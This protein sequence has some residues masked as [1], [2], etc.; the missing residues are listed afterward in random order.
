MTIARRWLYASPMKTIA[1]LTTLAVFA[2]W[3]V[4]VGAQTILGSRFD[5]SSKGTPESTRLRVN[6]A[7]SASPEVVSGDAAT[8][9]ATVQIIVNGGTPSTLTITLP[10][11]S[12]WKR[13]PF[14]TAEPVQAWKYRDSI[15]DGIVSPVANLVIARSS[16]GKFKLAASLNGRDVPLNVTPGNPGTYAGMVVTIPGGGTYCANFGGVAGGTILR[17]DAYRFRIAKPTAEGTCPTTGPPVCGDGI[18]DSPFETCDVANDAACP[19]ICGANG[20][21]CLCPF[22]GDGTIDPGE[23]CDTLATGS[24][25]E[26]CSY[27]CTCSVCGDGVIQAPGEECE[28]FPELE[29]TIGSCGLPGEPNQCRCPTCGDG[30]VTQGEECD[31]GSDAACPGT[32]NTDLCMCAVCGNMIEEPGEECD[33]VGGCGGGGDCLPN[34]TCSECGNGT[35]EPPVEQCEAGVDETAC[36]GLCNSDCVC[37]VCGNDFTDYPQEQCDG[38]DDGACPNAC[39]VD[40]TCP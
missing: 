40:C 29:C 20:L 8:N 25:T 5:L 3:I 10:G 12:G 36:P 15:G 13:S 30:F 21:D 39:Q 22:C 17:N 1:R 24:C 18:V 32:C 2:L 31:V 27:A 11:G 16:S 26:G 7:E 38:T 6:A 19:G 4:P 33:T 14:D 35:F 9:G 34:C 28:S 23:S 37:G